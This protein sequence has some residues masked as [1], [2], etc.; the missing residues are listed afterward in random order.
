MFGNKTARRHARCLVLFA[1]NVELASR[2]ERAKME[3]SQLTARYSGCG[4][5]HDEI[6]GINRARGVVRSIK[7]AIALVEVE[8]ANA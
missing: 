4:L 6:P 1:R 2:L 5:A 8:L 7:R 3:V